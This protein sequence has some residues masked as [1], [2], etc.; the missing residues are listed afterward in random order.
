MTEELKPFADWFDKE[1]ETGVRFSDNV[2]AS[3]GPWS[4][5]RERFIRAIMQGAFYAGMNQRTPPKVKALD[6]V[7]L[8]QHRL[9]AG[10]YEIACN[11]SPV[12]P[13]AMWRVKYYGKVVCKKIKGVYR[14]KKWAND[15]NSRRVLACLE[16]YDD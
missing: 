13:D 11:D 2:T 7:E 9:G 5:R 8:R 16:G 10:P 14:A 12:S 3:L 6:W 1:V 15:H 4:E